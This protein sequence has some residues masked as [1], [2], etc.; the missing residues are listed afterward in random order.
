MKRHMRED[1]LVEGEGLLCFDENHEPTTRRPSTTAELRKFRFSRL[2]P[3]GR[4]LDK[5]TRT[6]L[7]EA[8]VNTASV[9]SADPAVP[10]G[11]TYLGQFVD[12]DLTM[13]NTAAALGEDVS[14]DELLQ[15]RSP[16]LDLDSLYGRG[17][18]DKTD[19]VFYAADGV[20]LKTGATAGLGGADPAVAPDRDGFD[21]PRSGLGSSKRERRAALIPDARNDENL[22]VAQTHLAFIRF[23][24]RVVDQLAEGGLSGRALFQAAR[25]VVVRHYQWLLVHDFLP[26]IVSP[27]VVEEVFTRGRK[28]FEVSPGY[29]QR[30]RRRA[31]QPGDRPTMP[32]EFSVAAYRLGHSMIREV[33]DWNRIFNTS[34]HRDVLAPG[35]LQLLFQFSGTSGILSPDGTIAD[36]ES[37][38]FERLPTNWIADWRR[39]FDFTEAGRD[40]LVAVVDVDENDT[41]PGVR[42]LNLTKRIDTNLVDPLRDLPLGSFGGQDVP[43][44]IELNLAFRN[45]TRAVMVRLASGQQM[46]QLFD[47]VP[48]KADEILAGLDGAVLDGL[49]DA[50]KAELTTNTP[51]W[52][53][54][55]RE[56]EFNGGRLD[57]VGARIVAEVFHRAIEGSRISILR[58]P[59]WRPTLGPDDETFRMVDLLLYAFEGNAELLNPVGDPVPAT[60]AEPEVPAEVVPA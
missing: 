1:Y 57:G 36:P 45:L 53:Y 17:P 55:L 14:V 25:S 7:A 31:V 58:D 43:P 49:S 16:A 29:G 41:E 38:S 30:Q 51:L 47:L 10:A 5:R 4:A 44:A 2:G 42:Q 23:H 46:A 39:L 28:F 60:P 20:H 37:G 6:A 19:R 40:D 22:V 8:M 52:F 54:I 11:Y 59:T 33:Y 15:G 18:E 3:E 48:L 21:L 9:D 13:D 50:Q 12:H 56:A 26:R 34:T 24:N 27:E 32:I 35:T